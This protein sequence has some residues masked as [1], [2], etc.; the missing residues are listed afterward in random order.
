MVATT[1]AFSS[2]LPFLRRTWVVGIDL[3]FEGGGRGELRF[4][5]RGSFGIWAGEVAPINELKG[6]SVHVVGT[7]DNPAAAFER[8]A[9]PDAVGDA[10]LDES[11]EVERFP[12]GA[13]TGS[14][15]EGLDLLECKREPTTEFLAEFD[16]PPG[17]HLRFHVIEG[18]HEVALGVDVVRCDGCVFG[19][20]DYRTGH[21]GF[22]P[23][24]QAYR[25]GF[26]LLG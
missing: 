5:R 2:V 24:W 9:G 18:T 11:I 4:S 19:D 3:S 16:N 17:R 10:G 6:D 20:V 13:A 7:E 14:G 26:W 23:K 15:V 21:E 12:Y 8:V 25:R 22:T 1:A